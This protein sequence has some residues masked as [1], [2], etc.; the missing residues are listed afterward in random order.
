MSGEKNGRQR[1]FRARRCRPSRR[2]ANE[3]ATDE[4]R[5]TRRHLGPY[6]AAIEDHLAS[7]AD[8][9]DRLQRSLAGEIAPDRHYFRSKAHQ[10]ELVVPSLVRRTQDIEGRLDA[11]DAPVVRNEPGASPRGD[12]GAAPRPPRRA[13]RQPALHSRTRPG[14]PPAISVILPSRPATTSAG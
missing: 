7:C 2:R 1:R 13:R 3:E 6:R 9:L 14:T 4:Q 11:C 5:P 8:Y 10:L 12:L